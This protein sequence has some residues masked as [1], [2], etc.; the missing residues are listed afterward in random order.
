MPALILDQFVNDIDGLLRDLVDSYLAASIIESG[1]L[2]PD[3]GKR[4]SVKKRAENR[5]KAVLDAI[6]VLFCRWLVVRVAED[7]GILSK[8]SHVHENRA[9]AYE[10]QLNDLMTHFPFLADSL[11]VIPINL[12]AEQEEKL[13]SVLESY[14]FSHLNSDIVG[15]LYQEYISK[16]ERKS[17]G[18]YFTPD[19]IIDYTLDKIDYNVSKEIIGKKI[20]D[21]ACGAGG[22]L[23]RAADR[24][25]KA[26]SLASMTSW[27][28]LQLIVDS[29]YGVDLEPFLIYLARLNFFYVLGDLIADSMAEIMFHGFPEMN[30]FTADALTIPEKGVDVFLQSKDPLPSLF[31]TSEDQNVVDQIKLRQK[32]FDNG[33]DFVVMNPPYYKVR[34]MSP[35]QRVF[36]KKSLFGH[37]NAY[38]LFTHLGI[39]ITKENGRLG[40]VIPESIKSGLYFKNLRNYLLD[41]TMVTDVLSFKS[42]VSVFPGVLQAIM[43]VSLKKNWRKDA[44]EITINETED[45][46]SLKSQQVISS[47]ICSDRAIRKINGE[48]VFFFSAESLSYDVLEKVFTR[49][50]P[51][52]RLGYQAKT[53]QIVWNRLKGSLSSHPK[54]GFFPL[55]WSD[56]F[57][58]YRFEFPGNT[59]IR[60]RWIAIEK[61]TQF[62]LNQ[63]PAILVKRTTAKEQKKRILATIPSN[64]E[65]LEKGYFVE[66]HANLI[67]WRADAELDE[68]FVLAYLNST[69]CDYVFRI[70]NGNTQVSATELN[71]HPVPCG[72]GEEN[73]AKIARLAQKT[74][75]TLKEGNLVAVRQIRQE[76]D[77]IFCNIC[78]LNQEEISLIDS[79]ISY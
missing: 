12:S 52:R 47:N 1:E 44:Y 17:A 10:K 35:E 61:K 28:I 22:F 57:G 72:I 13:I 63:G 25:I 42:R 32:G 58:M 21:P 23:V 53:G 33:F 54:T 5:R 34:K 11:N 15:K 45:L 43:V 76:I 66:N 18:Q 9:R 64:W 68:Y 79:L 51:L 69:L 71:S 41:H 59:E 2:V 77:S 62:L 70:M 30:L 36:F 38:G 19:I 78:E 31:Q 75:K 48:R 7:K 56:N 24:L 4:E 6:Y 20:I 8:N 55:I 40:L 74:E 14:N 16:K 65:W 67:S 60:K 49:S 50:K 73:V 3:V 46:N 37:P 29:I 27:D 39:R 26:C